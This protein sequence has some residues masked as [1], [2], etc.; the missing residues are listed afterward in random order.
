[1]TLRPYYEDNIPSYEWIHANRPV[2][3][4]PTHMLRPTQEKVV[5]DRLLAIARGE[6]REGPDKCPHV[7]FHEGEFWIHNGNTAWTVSTILK[8]PN[9]NV[10]IAYVNGGS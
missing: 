9:M 1:M 7:I 6:P 5:I 2:V 10:R 4:V 8:Q 3:S